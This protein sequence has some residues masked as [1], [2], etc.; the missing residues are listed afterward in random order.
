[1]AQKINT[2]AAAKDMSILHHLSELRVRLAWSALA[3]AAG[4]IAAYCFSSEIFSLMTA[5]YLRTFAAASAQTPNAG[6]GPA[7]AAALIGTGPAEAFLLKIKVALFAGAILACP[8]IFYQ[9][10]LF[11]SPGLYH[12]EKKFAVPF[13]AG[14]TLLFLTGVLF[15]YFLVIPFALR[16]FQTE[17]VSIGLAP[18]IKIDEYLT[19]V[20]QCLLGFGIVFEMPLLAFF[21]AR[22]GILSHTMLIDWAR[23]AVVVIFIISAVLTP[24][25]VISQFLMAG[26]LLV[27]YGLSILVVRQ[28]Y[29]RKH[30]KREI[31]S[32]GQAQT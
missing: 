8:V 30:P 9:L 24:P 14:S 28:S 2:A 5:P 12:Q 31:E 21:L 27:L 1:M 19:L 18:V 10:W 23:P 22:F 13:L 3:V 11:V 7:A 26:P 15:C 16:F 32:A 29:R 25:D 17:Y 4:A 6:N 20:V